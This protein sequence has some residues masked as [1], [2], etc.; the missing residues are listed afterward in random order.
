MFLIVPSL[1]IYALFILSVTTFTMRLVQRLPKMFDIPDTCKSGINLTPL[2][3]WLTWKLCRSW[4]IFW[5]PIL[6]CDIEILWE[7][8]WRPWEKKEDG[9]RRDMK[10]IRGGC[11]AAQ[12]YWNGVEGWKI[13]LSNLKLLLDRQME[14][15]NCRNK[16][17]IL[18]FV[19]K[20]M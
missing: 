9:G 3:L 7:K 19:L 12:I 4:N 15:E 20:L 6:K 16:K 8:T 10:E 13:S 14:E 11:C 5:Y 18:R 17:R 1:C 2:S